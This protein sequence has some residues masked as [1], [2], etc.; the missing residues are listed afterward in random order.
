MNGLTPPPTKQGFFRNYFRSS[1]H[2]YPEKLRKIRILYVI[3]NL[4]TFH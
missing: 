4:H 3:K 2:T 1:G